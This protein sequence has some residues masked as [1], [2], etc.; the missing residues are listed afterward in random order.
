[1]PRLVVDAAKLEICDERNCVDI[2]SWYHRCEFR[3]ATQALRHKVPA[4][5]FAVNEDTARSV[6]RGRFETHKMMMFSY[7]GVPAAAQPG[8][9]D[10]WRQGN[11]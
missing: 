5:L 1:M 6:F 2:T 7:C 9:P 3:P 11:R 8:L 4:R 10:V